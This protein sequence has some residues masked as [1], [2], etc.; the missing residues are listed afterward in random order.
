MANGRVVEP[1]VNF[2]K[3]IIELGGDSV[4]K[5][6]QC[7]TCAVVCPLAPEENPFP[8]R[9]MILA[10]WGQKDKLVKD[11]AVWLCHNC[12]DCSLY[13]PR[14]A[15]PGDVLAAI[16]AY[17]INEYARPKWLVNFVKTPKSLP[18][19]IAFPIVILLLLLAITGHRPTGEEIRPSNFLPTYYIDAVFLPLTFFL[20]VSLVKS[21]KQFWDDMSEGLEPPS[22]FQL[23]LK[24]GWIGIIISTLKEILAHSRFYKCEANKGRAL[25]HMLLLW[26]FIALAIVT[27]IDVLAE[28][29]LHIEIPFPLSH[30]V[31]ILANL[32]GILLLIGIL[33]I[34]INRIQDKQTVSTYWDW[35]LIIVILAV[36]ITGFCAEFFRL[37]HIAKLAYGSYLIHVGFVFTLFVYLP[38]S[39]F[40][41]LVYRTVAMVHER[42]YGKV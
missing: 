36:G 22:R 23:I 12:N 41:H 18:L 29:I 20:I 37:I 21:I 17:V 4:K 24:G 5:C 26:S 13:C 34:L 40:A 28:Y 15:R 27:S 19:L 11:P 7:A 3:G 2:I 25:P 10:Q 33:T 39:K 32:G 35:S 30:P 16:R 1:D 38:Y 6:F 8:R 9:Q 31:K 42:Y 14:G